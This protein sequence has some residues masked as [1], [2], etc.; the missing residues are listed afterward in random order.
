MIKHINENTWIDLG[1]FPI[2]SRGRIDWNHSIGCKT[3]FMYHSTCGKIQIVEKIRDSVFKVVFYVGCDT[4]EYQF[5]TSSIKSCNFGMALKKPVAVT[6]PE[7]LKYFANR[8]DA[9]KYTAHSSKIIDAICPF[10]GLAKKIS[11]HDLTNQG[12]ACP[13]C[14]DGVSYPNKLM[15]NVLLQL[16]LD[17]KKE[18]SKFCDGFE[19]VG[20]YKYDFY[21]E[22]DQKRY[23]IEMDGGFHYGNGFLPH[24]QA[25]LT[26]ARKDML[27]AEHGISMI[28]INCNYRSMPKRLEFIKQNILSSQ[29]CDILDLSFI[30]WDTANQ[31]AVESNIKLAATLWNSTTYC[32]QE[33]AQQLG[34]KTNTIRKYLRLAASI[35]LCDY[36]HISAM[37][38]TRGINNLTKDNTSHP[39]LHGSKPKRQVALYKN[40]QLLGMFFSQS[41]LA[42]QSE[43]VCGRYID[44]KYISRVCCGHKK[45]A[46]GFVFKL[47]TLE[48]YEQYITCN[49]LTVQN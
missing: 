39:V 1:P 12:L 25:Q 32:T 46:Y 19:W 34:L 28:R 20:G 44:Q 45:S 3:D 38:R 36:N 26:D 41:E 17:F 31:I 30:S 14:T 21:F 29:L 43:E 33:I 35:G 37:H 11:V 2:D 5:A 9:Y 24:T 40:G 27:A 18:I 16:H 42:R 23:F 8:D 13:Q 22:K 48:E 49:S 6:H 47:V 7:L 10:C 15:Y 4:I